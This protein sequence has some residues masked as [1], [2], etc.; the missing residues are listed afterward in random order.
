MS[1]PTRIRT[2]LMSVLAASIC[3]ATQ[4]SHAAE[5]DFGSLKL[6]TGDSDTSPVP[7]GF[8]A[9]AVAIGFT[10]RYNGNSNNSTIIPGA[11][12]FGDKFMY[13]GDRGRYYFAQGG[14]AAGFVYGRYRFGNLDPEDSSEFTGMHEREG[15]FEMGLGANFVTP[16][17]LLTVR[18]AGDVTGTS[19]GSELLLWSDFPIVRGRWLFM[20]GIGLMWR[21]SKMANYY[22]GGVRPDEATPT[23]AAH[24]TGSTISPMASLVTTYRFAPN[25]LGTLSAGYEYFDNG[26]ANSPLVNHRNEWTWFAGVGYTW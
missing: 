8:V 3:L 9:G 4:P 7:S 23:R 25:W 15:E 26:I 11:V 24:D 2:A 19:K 16:Y 14:G 6:L 18:A 20:P 5:P 12:Y 22:F 10:P 1:Y 13:L 21:S 17:A